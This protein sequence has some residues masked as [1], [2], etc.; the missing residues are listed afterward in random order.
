MGEQLIWI[1][2]FFQWY[3][4]ESPHSP[5]HWASLSRATAHEAA[6]VSISLGPLVTADLPLWA[7]GS[8]SKGG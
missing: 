7:R 1:C 8:G 4:P 6:V 5:G 3:L 2:A